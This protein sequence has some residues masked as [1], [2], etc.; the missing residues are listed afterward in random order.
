MSKTRNLI[1]NRLSVELFNTLKHGE[2]YNT[3]HRS[4]P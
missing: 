1:S 4:R 2:K 3:G